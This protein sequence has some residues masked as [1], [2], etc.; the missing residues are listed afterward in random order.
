MVV[1][2]YDSP[3]GLLYMA[4]IGHC[5]CL[6]S[7]QDMKAHNRYLKN[8]NDASGPE[9][10]NYKEEWE[11]ISKAVNELKEYFDG[12]RQSFDIPLKLFGTAF[13]KRVWEMLM[14][15]PYGDTI[16]YSNLARLIGAPKAVRAV[17]SACAKN[18]VSIFVPCH[19]AVGRDGKLRGYAGGIETKQ[20]L[21]DLERADSMDEAYSEMMAADA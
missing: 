8:S 21:I 12:V 4:S 2:E 1:K 10:S 9:E 14:T 15:V 11:V 6:C 20:K 5:L 18:P 7:W 17:A 19:R 13:Q 3:Y 16:T